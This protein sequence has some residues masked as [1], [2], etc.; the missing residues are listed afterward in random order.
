MS[1]Q[2]VLLTGAAG[3]IGRAAVQALTVRGFRGYAAV[4]PPPEAALPG[5]PR[6]PRPRPRARAMGLLPPV[7]MITKSCTPKTGAKVL[8]IMGGWG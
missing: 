7:P 2:A 8:A 5:R 3:G 4:R 1:E 6:R